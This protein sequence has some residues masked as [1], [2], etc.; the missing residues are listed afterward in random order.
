MDARRVLARLAETASG[1]AAPDSQSEL[2]SAI[3]RSDL[4][5]WLRAHDFAALGF[6]SALPTDPELAAMLRQAALGAAAGNLAHFAALD[7]IERRFETERL[8]MV[9]LKGAAVASSAYRD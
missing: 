8:P 6:S 1:S 9:L 7:R 2:A 3:D 5:D 4:V